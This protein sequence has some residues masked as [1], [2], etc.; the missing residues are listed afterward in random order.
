MH[1][2]LVA[3]F[4]KLMTLVYLLIATTQ[5]GGGPLSV[6]M[7]QKVNIS[8]ARKIFPLRFAVFL[9]TSKRDGMR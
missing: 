1:F 4:Q 8:I 9:E 5:Y 7:N 2:M 6:A 3:I